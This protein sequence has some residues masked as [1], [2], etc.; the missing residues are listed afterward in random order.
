MAFKSSNILKIIKFQILIFYDQNT[1][2]RLIQILYWFG[3]IT[4]LF[5]I[6]SLFNQLLLESSSL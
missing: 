1:T 4:W 3:K 5:K 6:L 2:A